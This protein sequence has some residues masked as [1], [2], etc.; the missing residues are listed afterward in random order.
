MC[1]PSQL[2]SGATQCGLWLSDWASVFLSIEWARVQ[3][4]LGIAY[5]PYSCWMPRRS[6][7]GSWKLSVSIH[8]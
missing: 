2:R 5:S 3:G 1:I 6:S 7:S 8:W 4:Q